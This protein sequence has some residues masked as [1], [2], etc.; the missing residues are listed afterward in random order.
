MISDSAAGV[1][2]ETTEVWRNQ[3]RAAGRVTAAR[4]LVLEALDTAHEHLTIAEVHARVSHSRQP[5]NL[6]TVYRTIERLEELGLVHR[7]DAPGDAKYG[8]HQHPHH[9]AICVSCE[10][11]FELASADVSQA[12]EVLADNT[13]IAPDLT[14]SLTIR[15]TCAACLQNRLCDRED[16]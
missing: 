6:S 15:I 3:L 4:L 14:S 10:R 7:L 12:L 16:V 8:L 1:G 2:P 5:V 11:V 13:G 9:H